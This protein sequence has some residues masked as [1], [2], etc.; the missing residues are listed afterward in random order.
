VGEAAIVAVGYGDEFYTGNRQCSVGITLA[1]MP[2][3]MSANWTRSIAAVVAG[4]CAM[5]SAE[6]SRIW[7]LVAA[8]ARLA[9]FRKVLRSRFI[10]YSPPFQ[11]ARQGMMCRELKLWNS[12]AGVKEARSVDVLVKLR[13]GPTLTH[14]LTPSA[15]KY[16]PT[17][18]TPPG[19]LVGRTGSREVASYLRPDGMLPGHCASQGD[20]AAGYLRTDRVC[21]GER[22]GDGN[23]RSASPRS[24][25]DNRSLRV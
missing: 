11:A 3:P 22:S 14:T 15:A 9:F 10:R 24:G 1:W 17:S 19:I 21:K 12:K 23:C 25:N 5:A 6:V 7:S 2:A 4:C 16:R 18:M 8:A 20:A 13:F